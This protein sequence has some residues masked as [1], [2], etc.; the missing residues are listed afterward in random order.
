[1]KSQKIEM[2]A[3]LISG[4]KMSKEH[5]AAELSNLLTIPKLSFE[6]AEEESKRCDYAIY[7]VEIADDNGFKN[8]INWADAAA[9]FLEGYEFARKSLA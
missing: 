8:E 1:M 6:Q 7:A 4:T 5:I 3:L 2:L 9:F